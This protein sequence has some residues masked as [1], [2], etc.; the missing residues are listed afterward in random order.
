MLGYAGLLGSEESSRQIRRRQLFKMLVM[1][2]FHF[3]ELCCNPQD[4]PASFTETQLAL[5]S[6]PHCIWTVRISTTE[7]HYSFSVFFSLRK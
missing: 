7:M 2:L 5:P 4:Q 6:T 1:L 3:H